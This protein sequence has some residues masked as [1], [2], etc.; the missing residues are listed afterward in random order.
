MCVGKNSSLGEPTQ[1]LTIKK[2]H[3]AKS[4]AALRKTLSDRGGGVGTRKR[5]QE[6]VAPVR[7]CPNFLFGTMILAK[8]QYKYRGEDCAAR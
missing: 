8:G 4:G 2:I 3:K 6:L 7:N 1:P 5:A